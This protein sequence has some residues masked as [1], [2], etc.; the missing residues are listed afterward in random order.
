M[1]CPYCTLINPETSLRCDCGY[2]FELKALEKPYFKQAFPEKIRNYLIAMI[3]LY[4]VGIST[5][6]TKGD[7]VRLRAGVIGILVFSWYYVNLVHK[8]N[9]ARITLIIVTFPVG[10]ML[11]ADEVRRYCLLPKNLMRPR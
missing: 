7:M 1:K 4:V 6:L 8:K 3:V 11:I 2:N 5:A 9:W 10:L